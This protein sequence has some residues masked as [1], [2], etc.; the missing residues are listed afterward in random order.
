MFATLVFWKRTYDFLQE[1]FPDIFHF[2]IQIQ[3]CRHSWTLHKWHYIPNFWVVFF[4][5]GEG[6]FHCALSTP[7][8]LIVAPYS[9]PWMFW[10]IVFSCLLVQTY[11]AQLTVDLVASVIIFSSCHCFSQLYCLH[12]V[13]DY[14]HHTVCLSV[15][16]AVKFAVYVGQ[17]K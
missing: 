4:W 5:G 11:E 16:Y 9:T 10:H 7:I 17:Y 8:L 12:S 1:H 3:T 14:W 15:F 2:V 6:Q 13:V